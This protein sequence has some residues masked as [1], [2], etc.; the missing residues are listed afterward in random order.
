MASDCKS[1]RKKKGKGGKE[2]KWENKTSRKAGRKAKRQVGRQKNWQTG[3]KRSRKKGSLRSYIGLKSG[4]DPPLVLAPRRPWFTVLWKLEQ[5]W[6]YNK[7]PKGWEL[8][9]LSLY[10]Y[11][12]IPVL[13]CSYKTRLSVRS[14]GDQEWRQRFSCI[15]YYDKLTLVACYCLHLPVSPLPLIGPTFSTSFCSLILLSSNS[16]R[17]LSFSSF[18]TAFCSSRIAFSFSSWTNVPRK[19]YKCQRHIEWFFRF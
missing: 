1:P 11:P 12:A 19:P 7:Q 17:F 15:I 5:Q 8:W 9:E 6:F 3:M 2:R 10:H 4:V 18:F 16:F 14:F 13:N